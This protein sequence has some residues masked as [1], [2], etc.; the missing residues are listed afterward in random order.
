MEPIAS[1]TVD[2]IRLVPGI[3]VSRI[4]QDPA[5]GACITTFDLRFTAPNR[6]PVMDTATVHALEHLGATYLRN[7][8]TWK[9]RI[10]YFG[11]MGCR[12]GFYLLVFGQATS[13]DVAPL[14]RDL[15][16]YIEA[17]QGDAPGAYPAECGNY[18]D[19]DVPGARYWAK[20]YRETVLDCLS[21]ENTQYPA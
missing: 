6:E 16:A 15:C 19:S 7:N 17:Y 10:V 1:F 9:N 20:R 3:Y 13:R 11:P 2:H 21:D 18:H 5:S 14:L 4:D 12:T 8:P